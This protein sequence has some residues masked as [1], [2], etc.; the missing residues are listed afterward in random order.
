MHLIGSEIPN[1]IFG[2]H[3]FIENEKRDVVPSLRF[4]E[5]FVF[6]GILYVQ[7]G[8]HI[9]EDEQGVIFSSKKEDLILNSNERLNLYKKSILS[10][11]FCNYIYEVARPLF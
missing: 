3:L 6:N 11:H 10:G 4:W 8:K 2:T 7:Q 1:G 5:S 9:L